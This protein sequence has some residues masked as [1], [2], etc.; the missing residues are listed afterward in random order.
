LWL[1]ADLV[2]SPRSIG[3]SLVNIGAELSLEETVFLWAGWAGGSGLTGGAAIGVGLDY[4]RFDVGIARSFTTTPLQES[5]PIQI[6]F[7][8]R[9]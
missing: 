1:T 4:D 5:E 9:F 8:I 3:E 2:A 6:T 7:G